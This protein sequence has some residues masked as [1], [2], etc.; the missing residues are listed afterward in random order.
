MTLR[1][2]PAPAHDFREVTPGQEEPAAALAVIDLIFVEHAAHEC[3][4]AART[5]DVRIAWAEDPDAIT[6]DGVRKR[7]GSAMRAYVVAARIECHRGAAVDAVHTE[8][9]A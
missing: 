2:C 9:F 7:G 3:G 1:P 6:G 8:I 5:P 4:L